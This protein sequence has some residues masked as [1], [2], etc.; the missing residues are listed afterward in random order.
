MAKLTKKELKKKKKKFDY[1]DAFDSQ[2]AIAVKEAKLLKEIVDSFQSVDDIKESQIEARLERAHA[3]EREGDELCHRV[4][5]VLITDF[6]TPID[7][8]DIITITESLD[9]VID[10]TEEIIQRFYMYDIHFMHDGAKKFVKLIVRSCEALSNAMADF[11]NCKKS[12]KFKSL[13]YQ[14]NELEDEA[15]ALYMKLIRELYTEE[16]EHPMRVMVWTR[17]FDAMED[18]VDQ[19][20]LVANKMNMVMVKYA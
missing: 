12:S 9:E 7:R 10:R 18:C 11:R 13:I 16:R 3:L 17:L 4:S 8:E 5:E 1:Y 2:A 15:D 14:V 19:C 20:E 6:V